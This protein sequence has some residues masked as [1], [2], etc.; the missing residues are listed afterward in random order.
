MT[1]NRGKTMEKHPKNREPHQNRGKPRKTIK[2]T[3]TAFP[4][5]VPNEK[6]HNFG[7]VC[8]LETRCKDNFPSLSASISSTTWCD[9]SRVLWFSYGM[10]AI[11]RFGWSKPWHP[12]VPIKIDG[13]FGCSSHLVIWYFKDV[14]PLWFRFCSTIMT[15][16]SEA[17]PLCTNLGSC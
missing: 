11:R 13:F 16:N 14:D 2:K 3:S 9:R 4:H 7:R 12:D 1:E 10:F 15:C 6:W 8:P 17:P 5:H